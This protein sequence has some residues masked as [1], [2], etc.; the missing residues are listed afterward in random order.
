MGHADVNAV[1]VKIKAMAVR[2]S[3][4]VVGVVIL[5]KVL[6]RVFFMLVLY[7]KSIL[8]VHMGDLVSLSCC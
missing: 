4:M 1:I 2:A 3:R 8:Q 5:R 6:S 7:L